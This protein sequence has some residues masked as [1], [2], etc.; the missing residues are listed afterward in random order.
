M[1]DSD[2]T[3]ASRRREKVRIPPFRWKSTRQTQN[4]ESNRE[5]T[6]HVGT[7]EALGPR[8]DGSAVS[9][10]TR[11]R[12]VGLHTASAMLQWMRPGHLPILTG[13]LDSSGAIW[14]SANDRRS[15]R[16]LAVMMALNAANALVLWNVFPMHMR[17][18]P[19]TFTDTM[20]AMRR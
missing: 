16:W 2:L 5:E 20:H 10:L 7:A 11:L 12:G 9:A 18:T 8:D 17:G 19:P 6:I 14:R 4:Y 13:T 3:R 15:L 1:N